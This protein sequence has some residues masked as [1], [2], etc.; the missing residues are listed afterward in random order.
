LLEGGK[1]VVC[2]AEAA[3][4]CPLTKGERILAALDGSEYSEKAFDQA[5]SMA[6]IC[7]S[8]LFAISVVDLYPEQME[9]AP[10]LEEKMS[11]EARGILERAKQKAEQENI[12]C[13]T[14]VHMGGP[15]NEF[16]VQEAKEKNIDLIVMGTHGRTGLKRVIMG[17][18]AERVIGHAPCAVLVTPL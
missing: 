11:A 14:I 10:A 7:N 5:L 12:A 9:L 1:E 6:R 3:F 18:V 17:S 2:M 16:I 15:A 8:K 13:E 4:A